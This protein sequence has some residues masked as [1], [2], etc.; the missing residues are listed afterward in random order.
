MIV[1]INILIKSTLK[2]LSL[3][4][5]ICRKILMGSCYFFLS[6][7]DLFCWGFCFCC[8]CFFFRCLKSSWGG[9]LA[10]HDP[11][12]LVEYTDTAAPCVLR[13]VGAKPAFLHFFAVVSWIILSSHSHQNF[14]LI[15]T[16]FFKY[17]Y[18]NDNSFPV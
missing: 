15:R 17:V 8:S 11:F 1:T 7:N 16:W 4:S 6:T 2:T 18:L 12:R 5:S 10:V 9:Q 14:K 3:C 13:T